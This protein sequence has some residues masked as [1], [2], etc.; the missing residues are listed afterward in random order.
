LY[1][2]A[3]FAVVL[4]APRRKVLAAVIRAACGGSGVPGATVRVAVPCLVRAGP[5]RWK[6]ARNGSGRF[7]CELARRDER[8]L[9]SR[10]LRELVRRD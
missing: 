9:V 7:V 5:T 10:D 8:E 1:G 4:A 6:R 2:Q 3:N